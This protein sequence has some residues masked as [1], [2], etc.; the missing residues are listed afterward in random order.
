MPA[1]EIPLAG[2]NASLGVVRVGDTV[3]KPWTAAS[4]AV[5]AFTEWV[6]G[7]GVDVPRPLGRDDRGRQVSEFVA[8]P[9]AMDSDRL[10][11]DDLA[12]VGRLVRRIHDAAAGFTPPSDAEWDVLIPVPDADL[13]C[14]NDLAP[15]NLIVGER[16][17]F[18]DW[19]GA[20]PS[21][22][23]WDLAYAAQA[24]TLN[25][26]TEPPAEAAAR[27]AAFLD[28]YRP[29]RALRA[30]LPRTLGERTAAMHSLLR[31]AHETGR[32]PWGTMYVEGHGEHWRAATEYVT[33]HEE[34]WR[35]ALEVHAPREAPRGGAGGRA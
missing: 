35:R 15:W 20:G 31:T 1:D 23:L 28:G 4:P 12:R 33:A 26:V 16:W 17:V 10:G 14:H 32:E 24:F 22:R 34:V 30:A 19:D 2:G 8:G 5:T 7:H 25:D 3:R 29:D 21:T 27:L 6:G 18:I 9:L 13:V 11:L